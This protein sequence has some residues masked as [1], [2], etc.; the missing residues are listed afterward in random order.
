MPR[1][2]NKGDRHE[3]TEDHWP[4]RC[5][6]AGRGHRDG[7]RVD[8]RSGSSRSDRERGGRWC[9]DAVVNAFAIPF[10]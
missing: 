5:G 6:L 3:I 8:E 7:A 4:S 10:A 2:G 9:R 1:A